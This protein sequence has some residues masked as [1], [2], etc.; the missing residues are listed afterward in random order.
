[1]R[2]AATY[3]QRTLAL[4]T[5]GG[6]AKRKH[7]EDYPWAPTDDPDKRKK[8]HGNPKHWHQWD[9]DTEKEARNVESYFIDKGMKGGTGGL[10][11]ADYVY[12][13]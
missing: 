4:I 13:F 10:G 3:P 12:I 5:F 11:S 9:A 2:F 8:E 6:F 1:M 7:S